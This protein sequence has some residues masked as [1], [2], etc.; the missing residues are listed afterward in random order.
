MAETLALLLIEDSPSDAMLLREQLHESM[1]G[2][3]S[4]EHTSTL[5][6]GLARLGQGG[7]DAVLLD[8]G[9][10][11][12]SGLE[13]FERVSETLPQPAVVV[14]TGLND[15]RLAEE[16]VRLGAQDYMVKDEASPEKLR[17]SITYAV[18]RQRILDDLEHV[19]QEQL[20]AKD[21]FLSHV[22]HEL[23]SPLAVIHQFV[24]LLADGVAGPLSAEQ[25]DYLDVTTRNIEQLRMMIDDLLDV[26]RLQRGQLSVEVRAAS[27]NELLAE[28][29]RS[30]QRSA[31]DKSIE[32]ELRTWPLPTVS[33]DP[34]RTR[35]VLSNLLDNAIKFTPSAG[36][37][38]VEAASA[39]NQVRISVRDTGP[40]I[41]PENLEHV[42]EQFFQEPHAEEASRNGLG[43]G[44]FVSRELVTR[45]GGAIWAE[46]EPGGGTTVTFTL[47]ATQARTAR[48]STWER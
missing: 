45:Q 30:F 22:S 23:R 46:S 38:R 6:E 5:E 17:Q 9:L 43:V 13:T 41:Q 12:S 4:I 32:L 8:L 35:Q 34:Q 28:A 1:N 10:P 18:R 37:V 27:L 19:R 24:S 48:R 14:I 3:V 16:A 36:S 29:V 33:C 40:G 25:R 21:R 47:P 42:F 15:A 26:G 11:D 7:I 20:A 39:G 2:D 31:Q 44:L